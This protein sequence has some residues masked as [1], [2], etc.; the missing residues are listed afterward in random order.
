MAALIQQQSSLTTNTNR[1]DNGGWA[2][3][4]LADA[5]DALGTGWA[6]TRIKEKPPERRGRIGRRGRVDG[7]RCGRSIQVMGGAEK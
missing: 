6:G 4:Q 1:G 2:T 5:R 3:G 7:R